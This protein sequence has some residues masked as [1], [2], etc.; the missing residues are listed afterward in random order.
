[1]LATHF[2]FRYV[3]V[4][5][6]QQLHYF[7]GNKIYFLFIPPTILFIIWT[8][9]IYFNF[10]PNQIKKDFFRNM[11]WHSYEEDIDRIAFMG[12]LYFTR[13]EDG[14]RIFQIPDLLGALISCV[15]MTICLLTC[16]ICAYKTYVKLNDLTIEMSDRTRSLN[17]Q[18]FWTLGLQTLLPFVTQYI[19]VGTMFL[20][21]FFEIRFGRIGNLVGAF[22]SLYP[23]MDPIIAIFMIDRFRSFIL[24]KERVTTT[25]K[26]STMNDYGRTEG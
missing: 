24:R 3:D 14:R 19:P 15:I 9:S 4:C 17:K 13:T 16:V 12:P 7:E 1:M 20:L 10:G 6:P 21:P 8:F 26:V 22:C 2:I 25:S 11:T 18:L 23:A 5:K